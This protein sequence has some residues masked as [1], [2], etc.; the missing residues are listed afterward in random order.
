KGVISS[1]L[2]AYTIY[3][4]GI[5][6]PVIFGFYKTKLRITST[7]AL[8]A[9][10]GGGS[11]GLVSKITGIQYLDLGALAFG[12]FLLFVVS[13]IDNRIKSRRLDGGEAIQ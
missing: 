9:L 13:F 3:T 6:L 2:F 7:G 8:A 11:L 5:I 1:L 12:V 4:A 10:I